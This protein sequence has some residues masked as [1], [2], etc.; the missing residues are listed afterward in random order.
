[1]RRGHFD[2]QYRSAEA[3]EVSARLKTNRRTEDTLL[4]KKIQAMERLIIHSTRKARQS[5][6]EERERERERES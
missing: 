5:E 6:G 3:H 4:E 1:M 2:P